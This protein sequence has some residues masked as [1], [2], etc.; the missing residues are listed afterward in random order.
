MVKKAAPKFIGFLLAL[1]LLF[2]LPHRAPPYD[3]DPP[4]RVARLGYIQGAVSFEPAGT[5][6]WVDAE[7]NRPITTG[8]R[9]WTDQGSRA[10]LHM[11]SASIHLSGETGFF[12]PD[13]N[14]RITQIRLTEGSINVRVRRLYRDETFEID[15]PNLA[16]TIWHP[17]RYRSVASGMPDGKG[18]VRR[19]DLESFVSVQPSDAHVDGALGQTD[20]RDA[21]V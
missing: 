20:L 18:Q 14:D 5:E 15:T 21:I 17:G 7:I 13:L 3:D 4:S 11:G 9:I 6:D 12:F 1:G 16:F 2:A 8:D 19:V 10:E